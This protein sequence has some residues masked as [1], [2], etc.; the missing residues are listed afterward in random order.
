[1]SVNSL[2]RIYEVNF[3]TEECEIINK[4]DKKLALQGMINGNLFVADLFSASK[5]EV[6]WF[7]NKDFNQR[8]S[9]FGTKD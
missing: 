5:G 9:G 1:M 8:T 2:T 4:K 7:Y 3:R 6:R